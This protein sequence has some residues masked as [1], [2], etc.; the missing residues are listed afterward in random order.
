MHQPQIA[1]SLALV[2]F[3][4]FLVGLD[5]QAVH[6]PSDCLPRTNFPCRWWRRSL[7]GRIAGANAGKGIADPLVARA[8]REILRGQPLRAHMVK[9]QRLGD[10]ARPYPGRFCLDRETGLAIALP[11]LQV[12]GTKSG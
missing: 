10:I 9:D 12:G 7:S 11:A 3:E 4:A 1:G 6:F 2:E 8:A 5:C